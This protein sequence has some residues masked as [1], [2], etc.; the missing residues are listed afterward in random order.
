MTAVSLT[1][2]RGGACAPAGRSSNSWRN[3]KHLKGLPIPDCTTGKIDILL[4]ANVPE[5]IVQREIRV[6]RAG[7]PIAIRTAFGW[8]LT[9]S[10][11]NFAS[12][13]IKEVAIIGLASPE[14]HEEQTIRKW[15]TESVGTKATAAEDHVE[16]TLERR[17]P[18]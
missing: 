16:R 14:N 4:G 11:S 15:T 2:R 18:I 1:G 6:G 3:W 17:L 9:G 8:S 5:A 7:Q 12:G 10:V 13:T